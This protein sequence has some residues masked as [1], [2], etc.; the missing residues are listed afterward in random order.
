MRL[1]T[2]SL[3]SKS[4]YLQFI[5]HWPASDWICQEDHDQITKLLLLLMNLMSLGAPYLAVRPSSLFT[6]YNTRNIHSIHSMH[7]EKRI[8]IN[9]IICY[10]RGTCFSWW[11]PPILH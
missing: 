3:S 2:K 7:T 8:R 4:N 11:A 6:V 9:A 5:H 1:C 10:F